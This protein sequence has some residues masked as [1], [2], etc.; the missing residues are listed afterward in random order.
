MNDIFPPGTQIVYLP[1]H[2]KNN[3]SH[4]D[5]EYGF[6]EGPAYSKYL[7]TCRFWRK[8]KHGELRTVANGEVAEVDRLLRYNSVPQT[9]V[10][11]LLRQLAT[12]S[13]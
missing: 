2:A 10:D 6:V 4:L 1:S 9:V 7:R 13:E 5:V 8:D 11:E 3:L 12:V